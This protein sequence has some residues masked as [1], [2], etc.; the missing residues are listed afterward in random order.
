MTTTERETLQQVWY[1]QNYFDYQTSLAVG[2]W[3]GVSIKERWGMMR[4]GFAQSRIEVEEARRESVQTA[5]GSDTRGWLA[6]WH[7]QVSRR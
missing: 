4:K 7:R 2:F 1:A 6:S 5:V 3:A